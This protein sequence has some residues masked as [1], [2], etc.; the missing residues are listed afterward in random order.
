MAR[1]EPTTAKRVAVIGLG[2]FGESVA[3]TLAALGYEVTAID[4]DERRVAEIADR[5]TLA[6]QGDGADEEMLR[7]LA[8]DR[9]DVAI[10]G[11]GEN[12]EASVL[13]TLVL[14]R[15][16]IPWVI[17]KAETALHGELLARI[18][19]DRVVYPERAAGVRVAHSLTVRNLEDYFSLSATAGI[20][21]LAAP[22][23]AVGATIAR[24][25]SDA[26]I[27][28]LLLERGGRWQAA[29]PPAETLRADDVL[30][31]AGADAAIDAFAA[32]VVPA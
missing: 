20:A 7:S 6:A 11:Q 31:V 19:A 8:I 5:V 27:D 15:M 25:A 23:G 18:G 21:R 26:G 4:I 1:S 24:V 10:V 14:K 2:R 12:L 13:C 17:A 30:V 28:V 3:T 32:G 16:R 22:A 29:P 9:S